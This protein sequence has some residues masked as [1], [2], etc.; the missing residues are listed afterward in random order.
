MPGELAARIRAKY[1]GAY[2]GIDD[3]ALEKQVIA[4]YPQYATPP[5]EAQERSWTDTAVDAL[6]MVGGALGG[7]AGA[8]G[9]PVGA[10]G[11]AALGG[12]GGEGFKQSINA[13]R[14]KG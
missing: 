3:A 9:G 14:G 11:G 2:D 4:K 8:I 12:A 10:I 7:L 5:P 13:L 6:P 1:P